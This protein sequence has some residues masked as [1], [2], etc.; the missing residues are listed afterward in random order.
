MSDADK[1]QGMLTNFM[2]MLEVK[3]DHF[4]GML[5]RRFDD[6]EKNLEEKLDNTLIDFRESFEHRF[7]NIDLKLEDI[8]D[9]LNE[10]DKRFEEIDKRFEE[11]GE[12][13]SDIRNV[14]MSDSMDTVMTSREARTLNARITR[15]EA[16][17]D[18]MRG[19]A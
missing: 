18:R 15:I 16:E 8:K 4:E 5:D 17:L 9:Q 7:N 2:G 3:F 10:H 13:I 12:E 1:I 14:I 11:I 6:F 19:K